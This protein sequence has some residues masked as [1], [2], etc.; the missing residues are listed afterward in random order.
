MPN[1]TR[2]FCLLLLGVLCFPGMWGTPCSAGG[3]AMERPNILLIVSDALRA[4]VL[5]CYGG[6]ARTP[7][8]DR[9]TADGV[10]FDNAY[11][12]AP[13][14]MASAISMWSGNYSRAYTVVEGQQVDRWLDLDLVTYVSDEELLLGE[15][16][17]ENGY[18]VRMDIE[19]KLAH[20][21]NGLQGFEF[22]REYP[23]LDKDE[24]SLVERMVGLDV[25][26]KFKRT[27]KLTEYAKLYGV[28][29]Y[30][31]TVPREQ[32]FFAVKWFLDPHDPYH[33]VEEFRDRIEL[34]TTQL[35]RNPGVY[36]RLGP[37][38]MKDFTEIEDQYVEA[39]YCAEVESVDDRIGYLLAALG[40]RDLSSKTIVVFTSDHGE[41]F[42]AHDHRGHGEAFWNQL[43]HV[44]LIFAGPG[45]ETGKRITTYVSHLSLA[46]TLKALG[47]LDFQ[48]TYLGQSYLP[49]LRGGAPADRV[50]YFDRIGNVITE[51]N[52]TRMR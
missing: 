25:P 8:L 30:L 36:W 11:S 27:K 29:H 28:L 45:I 23:D 3:P 2:M 7:H 41:M 4:D 44:P 14:T 6:E 10:L 48:D 12:T 20:I 37:N 31:L 46:P 16:L 34:D 43:L 47:Q 17:R 9:L 15:A 24:V 50:L 1:H 13:A 32:P 38:D 40:A 51:R 35:P 33:P 52:S 5:G 42:G 26:V 22:I 21:T 18:E 49:L 19:N 39:L